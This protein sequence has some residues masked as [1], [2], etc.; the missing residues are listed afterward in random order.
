MKKFFLKT[1]GCQMN[2]S[3]SERIAGVL[4]HAGLDPVPEP[5]QA[6]VLIFNTCC[7]RKHAEDRLL[8]NVNSL[9]RLKNKKRKVII[10]I[11]G[12]FAQK[13]KEEV[14]TL[15][16]HVDLVFGTHN[17]SHLPRL[18][19][20]AQK[21]SHK[22]CEILESCDALPHKLPVKRDSKFFGWVPVSIGCNN[23]CSYCVVPYVRGREVS[24]PLEQIKVDVGKFVSHG[25]KEI[26]LLGQNVNSYG[27][28]FYGESRFDQ[29]L[30]ELGS[31]EGLER[32]RFTTS[33]PKDLNDRII[34]AISIQSKICEHV[35]LPIQAGSDRVLKLMNRGYSGSDYLQIVEKIRE[36]I[37]ECSLSTDIMVG[38]PGEREE[39]FERTLDMVDEVRFEQA[40][41]FIYSPREGTPAL[42]LPDQVP[43]ASKKE[44][45][46][47]LV[48]LQDK[49]TWEINKSLVG[50]RFKVLTEGIAKKDKQMLF[51]RT[52]TGKVVNFPASDIS[53]GTTVEVRIVKALKKSLLGEVC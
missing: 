32:I 13:Q 19:S 53:I 5:Q 33:H 6:D 50:R 29:L 41:T 34:D 21:N 3:D 31:V 10:A 35:H 36:K 18:I 25:G 42:N 4:L 8:G 38:F 2:K 46:L 39:D 48:E 9:K 40:F 12:C 28:D 43:E 20:A 51:G 52:R 45:F 16:P 37:P 17:I 24:L 26:T 23:F 47:R 14:F 22:V 1:F 44:R 30:K 11:G 49:I 27:R 7:V 15:M